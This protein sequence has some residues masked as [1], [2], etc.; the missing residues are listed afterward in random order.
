[1]YRNVWFCCPQGALEMSSPAQRPHS[2]LPH[3]LLF[4]FPECCHARGASSASPTCPGAL[5]GYLPSGSCHTWSGVPAGMAAATLPWVFVAVCPGCALVTGRVNPRDS[6]SASTAGSCVQDFPG[7]TLSV[8]E[9]WQTLAPKYT[10][11]VGTAVQSK[12]V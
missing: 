3:S 9:S 10:S 4:T 8:A 11:V 6:R 5:R 12:V 7:I 1:M 2:P